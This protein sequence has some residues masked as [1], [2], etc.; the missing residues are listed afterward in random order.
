MWALDLGTTNTGLARWDSV[1]NKPV[2]VDFPDLCRAPE[3][4]EE[5]EAPRM[6]PSAVHV[7]DDTGF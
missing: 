1:T 6:I 3:A 5:L 2:M 7:L 4:T